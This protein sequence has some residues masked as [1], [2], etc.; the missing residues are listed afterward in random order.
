MPRSTAPSCTASVEKSCRSWTTTVAS[1]CWRNRVATLRP[2]AES[3]AWLDE[4]EVLLERA[5]ALAREV[6]GGR[7]TFAGRRGNG[8]RGV[9]LALEAQPGQVTVVLDEDGRVDGA[10]H[11]MHVFDVAR[12]H[13]GGMAEA[14]LDP[15]GHRD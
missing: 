6:D 10:R 14:V 1:I 13:D 4:A 7:Q 12:V 3:S 15:A 8:K 9:T 5:A 2:R 11:R